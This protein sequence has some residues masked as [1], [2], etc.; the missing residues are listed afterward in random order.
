MND[1]QELLGQLDSQGWSKA[2]IA[3]AIGSHSD[4]V[5]RWAR[6][7]RY[8]ENAGG[9]RLQL[10]ELL[11]RRRGIPKRRRYAEGSRRKANPPTT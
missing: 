8:P 7:I 9:V 10:Q 11:K 3:A 1:I 2:A 4:T 6:G 5:S